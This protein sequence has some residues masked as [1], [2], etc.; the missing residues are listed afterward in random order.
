M[1]LLV[2][3]TLGFLMTSAL[4]A[5]TGYW[6]LYQLKT[7]SSLLNREVVSGIEEYQSSA[8][9]DEQARQVRYVQEVMVQSVRNY[10]FTGEKKWE[11]RYYAFRPEMAELTASLIENVDLPSH[12]LFQKIDH[13]RQNL[14]KIESRALLQINENRRAEAAT[15]LKAPEYSKLLRVVANALRDFDLQHRLGEHGIV[16]LRLAAQQAQIALQTSE[17]ISLL[18]VIF[19]V[20]VAV[21]TGIFMARSISGPIAS[22][23]KHMKSIGL[24]NIGAQIELPEPDKGIPGGRKLKTMFPRVFRNETAD[25]ARSFNQMSSWLEETVV[26]KDYVDNILDSVSEGIVTI[27]DKGMIKTF[28]SGVESI[29]GHRGD[30]MIGRNVSILLSENEH[31]EYETILDKSGMKSTVQTRELEGRRADGTLFPLELIVAPMTIGGGSG[32]VVTLRDI[33]ER[34]EIDKAKSEFVSTVSHELRTPLTSIKGALGLIKSGTVGDLPEKAT[35]MLNIAYNNSDRLVLLINDILDMEK[36]SS[37]NLNFQ[38]EPTKITALVDK[39]I[40]INQ[41]YGDQHNVTFVRTGND[42]NVETLGDT[43]RLMQVLSNLMS[44]AAKFSPEGGQVELSVRRSDG[45]ILVSVTDK[46]PGIPEEFRNRIFEKFT[47]ADSSDTRQIG[48]TGLGLSISRAIVEQHQGTINFES[49]IGEGTTFI[50]TLP[51]LHATVPK[52]ADTTT[53]VSKRRIL[54]CEDDADV[55]SLLELVLGGGGYSTT[56]ARTAG[57]A[58]ALLDAKP[59]DAMTLDLGRPDQ[60]G[61]SLIQDL[62]RQEKTRNLPIVVI[63]ATAGEGRQKLEGDVAGVIDWMEKPVNPEHLINRLEEGLRQLTS[64]KPRILHVEDDDSVLEIVSTLVNGAAD[65]VAARTVREARISLEKHTFDVVILDLVLPDGDGESLLPLLNMPGK[66]KTPVIVFSANDVSRQTV[67]KIE[68]ALVKTRT[69]NEVLLNT[70][71]ASID[72]SK[73]VA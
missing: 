14:L 38:F 6:G 44:N 52:E 51:D 65:I 54:I 31:G 34:S 53:D 49:K 62:R 11:Q 8:S 60:D 59:F 33:T 10:A 39:A 25:L 12:G 2:K 61:I 13:A 3:L 32:F 63:S 22:L 27:D 41:G 46:G 37:G 21:V 16:S 17:R 29:F 57:E 50:V 72:A 56:I 48:G 1:N 69:S 5:L 68:T 26:S 7:V 73:T 58:R 55:A 66:P 35:A 40:E 42:E 47:Q 45:D 20:V 70:I 36:V 71:R 64:A 19:V 23:S 43:D 67:A 15:L 4:A 18:F 24:H 9:I 28:N 30:E